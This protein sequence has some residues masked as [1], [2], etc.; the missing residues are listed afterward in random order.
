MSMFAV[1]LERIP[2]R[3]PE[4]AS[5]NPATNI[6][7]SCSRREM[8]WIN[9]A[10]V[11]AIIVR[12]KALQWIMARVI[13]NGLAGIIYAPCVDDA[14]R[15]IVATRFSFFARRDIEAPVAA[16]GKDGPGPNEA[17]ICGLF[18]LA[19]RQKRRLELRRPFRNLEV[20]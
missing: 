14:M 17:T 8:I 3:V 1:G 6:V 5:W 12:A 10:P 2:K 13:Q 11:N 18:D 9:T 20:R 4:R 19:L 7:A 15:S 16:G